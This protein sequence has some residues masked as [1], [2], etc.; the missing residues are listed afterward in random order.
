[1]PERA[2]VFDLVCEEHLG[3]AFQRDG[4]PFVV[5]DERAS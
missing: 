3:D 2:W 4:E 1:M 5:I